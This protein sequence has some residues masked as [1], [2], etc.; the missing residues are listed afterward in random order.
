MS[1]NKNYP[2]RKDWRKQ[3]VSI[4]KRCGAGRHSCPYCL[5]SRFHST[6]KRELTATEQLKEYFDGQYIKD[7]I[8]IQAKFKDDEDCYDEVDWEWFI[9]EI[10]P[11]YANR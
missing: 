8:I 5:G 11:V 1:F 7:Q 4:W 6:H 9:N 10:T 2:N 3:P